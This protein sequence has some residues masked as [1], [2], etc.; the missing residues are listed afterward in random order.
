M[1]GG[2]LVK[3]ELRAHRGG[4]RLAR[5]LAFHCPSTAVPAPAATIRPGFLRA[6]G[7]HPPAGGGGP[8]EGTVLRMG[9]RR[10]GRLAMAAVAAAVLIG[11]TA[12]PLAAAPEAAAALAP[13][14][15][16]AW[17]DNEF[18]QVGN[19]SRA[20]VEFDSPLFVTLPAAVK[21]VAAS[22]TSSPVPRSWPPAR[23]R[24]GAAT[25]TA[26]PAPTRRTPA[27]RLS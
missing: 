7:P 2:Q 27:S 23:P 10:R 25:P 9:G 11:G 14:S 20:T 6:R 16:F 18:G 13:P 12:A 26:R 17:G 24:S 3:N 5:A 4:L 21:Q 22:P 19:G 1:K 8:R 15:A